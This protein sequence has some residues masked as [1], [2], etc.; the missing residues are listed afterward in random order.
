MVPLERPRAICSLSN[1][2]I[3]RYFLYEE[4][5]Q[6]HIDKNNAMI[7]MLLVQ[8]VFIVNLT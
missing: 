1:L 4:K 5:P 8:N 6:L 3:H 7:S 2:R